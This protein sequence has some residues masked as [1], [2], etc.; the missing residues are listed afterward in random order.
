MTSST[1]GLLPFCFTS[2]QAED[3]EE[4]PRAFHLRRLSNTVSLLF[5][6]P[7][8]LSHPFNSSN[9][10]QKWSCFQVCKCNSFAKRYVQLEYKNGLKFIQRN[11]PYEVS[12]L[13]ITHEAR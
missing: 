5:D 3:G 13:V 10:H 1:H 7:S 6:K 12:R 11:V 4:Y 9:S 2:F 8:Q